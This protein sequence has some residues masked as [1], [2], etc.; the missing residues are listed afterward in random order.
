MLCGGVLPTGWERT[1][2][3][4]LLDLAFMTRFLLAARPCISCAPSRATAILH[5]VLRMAKP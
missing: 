2:A 4:G 3:S 5:P 1:R